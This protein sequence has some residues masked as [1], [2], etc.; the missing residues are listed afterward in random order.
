MRFPAPGSLPP[1]VAAYRDRLD[2]QILPVFGNIRVREL[3]VGIVDRHLRAV[4]IKHG[5][6]MAKQTKTVLGQV[7][8]LAVR[9]DALTQNPVRDA[10]RI[11]TKP[12][13]P[14]RALSVPQATQLMAAVTYDDQ[15]VARDLP[16]L[17]ATMLA[18][19]LRL[20]EACAL[21]W[22]SV[23]FMTGTLEVEATVVRVKGKGML[24]KSTKTTAGHR[25]LRL[26]RWCVDMLRERALP[27]LV[28]A[29]V[30]VFPAPK[31]NI[32]D[33]SNTAADLRD[34]F[35]KAGFAWATSHVLRK[36]TASVLDAGGLSAREIADQLGHAR[37][38][39]TMDR[40]MG[41]GIAGER[42]TPILEGLR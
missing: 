19:G 36:T 7:I 8:G 1:T 30:P 42:G 24:R 38:S 9:H 12:K 14:P 22:R 37:P 27:G 17:V 26:P 5:S 20:G 10:S 35:D 40:Y 29:N 6:A 33:P 3:T 28:D 4:G 32:R 25:T 23:D 21:L 34:A 41:R 16:A 18:S 39:I 13:N 11:S 2:K 31:G 15:A